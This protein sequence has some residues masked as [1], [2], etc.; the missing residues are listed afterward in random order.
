MTDILIIILSTLGSIFILVAALGILRMPDFYSRLSVT[1]KAATVG[2]GC[3][4]AATALHFSH[5]AVTTKV[6]AIIFF[7][8]ITSPVAAFMIARTAYMSGTK[9]WFKTL[10][11]ELNG[12]KNDHKTSR[13]N[14][15]T[16]PI[17]ENENTT[18]SPEKTEESSENI[19]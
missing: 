13:R 5:F 10:F 15:F 4:L 8:F 3:I 19:S 16:S 9:L 12:S 11:D 7:L 1:V 6:F 14:T 17:K 18:E 2:I